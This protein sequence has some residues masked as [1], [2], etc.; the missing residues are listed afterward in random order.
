V[1]YSSTPFLLFMIGELMAVVLMCA[2]MSIL[3]FG[4]WLSPVE[5]LPDGILWLVGKMLFFFFLF[6]MVKAIVPRYR[7][8][9]LMRIGWKVFLPMSLAWVVIVAALA[10][11][12]VPGYARW[13]VGG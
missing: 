7:Y 6:A 13:A 11:Y 4:G 5:F 10:Q 12:G 3:F 1:E 9:Q 8:D 2:L